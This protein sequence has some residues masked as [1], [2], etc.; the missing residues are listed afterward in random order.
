M[1]LEGGKRISEGYKGITM[2]VYDSDIDK[3][4]LYSYMIYKKPKKLILYG[5]HKNIKIK[6]GYEEILKLIKSKNNYIVKKFKRGNIFTGN[7]KHNFKNEMKSIRKLDKIYKDK[8]SYYT[9]IKPIFKYS[10]VDIY[11]ISFS[12]RFFIFQEKLRIL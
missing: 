5:L 3:Y 9:S 8:L 4:N 11:A 1:I 7:D 6:N 2:D 12:H 10:N